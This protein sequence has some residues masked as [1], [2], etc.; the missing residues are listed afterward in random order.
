M[1]CFRRRVGGHQTGIVIRQI[2]RHFLCQTLSTR[3]VAASKADLRG[4]LLYEDGRRD[5]GRDGRGCLGWSR[6]WRGRDDGAQCLVFWRGAG[7][8][9][10]DAAGEFILPLRRDE[11]VFAGHLQVAV[12]SDLRGFD[13]AAADLLPPRNIRA[14][15][16]VRPEAFEVAAL[17][18]RCLMQRVAHAGVP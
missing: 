17:R 7:K 1:G 14:P 3:R 12:A 13:G 11:G 9:L 8:L 16:R 15:E 4:G 2:E 10:L 6:R 5:G 18:L